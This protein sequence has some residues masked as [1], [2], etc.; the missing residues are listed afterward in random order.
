MHRYVYTAETLDGTRIDLDV[1][2]NDPHT[3]DVEAKIE[4]ERWL[5][6]E[7]Q[8]PE[9]LTRFDRLWSTPL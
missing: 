7:G 4:V 3:A 2:S 8:K 1:E 6:R 9:H 5:K